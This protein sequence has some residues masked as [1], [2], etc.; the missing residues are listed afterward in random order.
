M[1]KVHIDLQ[2]LCEMK[3]HIRDTFLKQTK[4]KVSLNVTKYGFLGSEYE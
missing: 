3:I 4:I 1:T 2:S